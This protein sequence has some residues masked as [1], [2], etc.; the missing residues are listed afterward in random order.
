MYRR[1]QHKRR[2]KHSSER[3]E[4]RNDTYKP[5]QNNHNNHHNNHSKNNYRSSTSSKKQRLIQVEKEIADIVFKD[6]YK[7]GDEYD[8]LMLERFQL[9][10]LLNQ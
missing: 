7:N 1:K 9:R 2:N 10:F 4:P 8:K 3:I 6:G 5:S